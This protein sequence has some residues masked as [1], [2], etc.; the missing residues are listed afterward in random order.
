[1]YLHLTDVSYED[2]YETNDNES[3]T[4]T[5]SAG[6]KKLF[7]R[8]P[9][10]PYAILMN[11]WMAY[12]GYACSDAQD[13]ISLRLNGK[14]I[15]RIGSVEVVYIPM[16][17]YAEDV[18]SRN[19]GGCKDPLITMNTIEG[20]LEDGDGRLVVLPIIYTRGWSL[21]IDGEEAELFK[22]NRCLTGFYASKGKHHFVLTYTPVNFRFAIIITII[23][24][25]AF[26]AVCVRNYMRRR[27]DSQVIQS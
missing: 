4:I 11:S 3:I 5:G 15:C 18:E 1:M 16:D 23:S 22:A 27:A 2:A 7:L 17:S 21:K 6:K 19:R 13:E 24:C 26:I 14:G 25:L 10:N 12:M 20:D 8:S 9:D